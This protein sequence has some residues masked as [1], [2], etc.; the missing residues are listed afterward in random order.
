MVCTA[1]LTYTG[2]SLMEWRQREAGQQQQQQQ[3]GIRMPLT[4]LCSGVYAALHQALCTLL[5]LP[6]ALPGTCTA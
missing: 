4:G 3:Q 5:G 6:L 1:L 2:Q